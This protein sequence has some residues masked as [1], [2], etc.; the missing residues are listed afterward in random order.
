MN[1]LGSRPDGWWRNRPAARRRLVSE[2][3]AFATRSNDPVTVIFDGRAVPEEV[4]EGARLGVEVGFA[5]GGRNA[6]DHVIAARIEAGAPPLPTVVTSDRALA[7]RV[8]QAGAMVVGVS[9]FRR[10]LDGE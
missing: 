9:A 7:A 10:L 1:V 4:E 5:P 6:A 2:L 3:A 8:A